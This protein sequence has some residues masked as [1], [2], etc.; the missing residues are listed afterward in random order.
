MVNSS[1]LLNSKP[2]STASF[3]DLYP[4]RSNF[5]DLR[6]MPY[7]YLD[8]GQGDPV[9]MVHGNPTWSFYYRNLVSSL[10]ENYRTIVPDHF[11]CGLSAKPDENQYGFTL[12]DRVQDL[13]QFLDQLNIQKKITLI[14]HDWGG[15]IGLACALENLKRIKQIILMNTAGF[16]PPQGRKIPFRLRVIRDLK[17]FANFCV[18]QLNL[19]AR[20]ALLMAPHNSLSRKVK[21]GL[22]APYNSPLNRLATLKFVQDIPLIASDPSYALV[23]KVDKNLYRLT[24]IPFLFLWG[25]HDFVFSMPYF[26]EWQKR[27]PKARFHLFNNAGHYVLEDVPDQIIFLIKNF[28]ENKA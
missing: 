12:K 26:N 18:L 16:F 14:L 21:C 25:K 4:F 24:D 28:L 13:T 23:T 27:F 10:K 2:V 11:G 15:M 6:G 9:V 20:A 1:K 19:F 7:H 3:R 5:M 22:I 17:P 8:E